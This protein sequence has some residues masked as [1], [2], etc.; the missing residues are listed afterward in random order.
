MDTLP[1]LQHVLSSS[2]DP[3]SPLA[4]ALVVLFEPSTTLFTHLVPQL[5]QSIPQT[6]IE[7]YSNLIDAALRSISTWDDPLKAEFIAG[8]PRIGEVKNLSHLSAKEQAAKATPPEVLARLAHLNA[9]YEHR[10]PGL[11]YITFVNGRTRAM[12]K[13][14]MEDVLGIPRSLS[15]DKPDIASIGVVEVGGE[16]WRRELERA[17]QD[18]G[19]IAKSRLGSL[20]VE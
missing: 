12:I 11:R 18:V 19:K 14:E 6:H 15:A 4:K 5:A 20:G 9:C 13:D 8:H 3:T 1:S 17:L 10:Y 2:A 16:V 7:T